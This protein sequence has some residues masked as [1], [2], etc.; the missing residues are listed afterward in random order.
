[1]TKFG[2]DSAWNGGEFCLGHRWSD[3]VNN[4]DNPMSS[5]HVPPIGS[6]YNFNDSYGAIGSLVFRA[7]G[8]RSGLTND[9]WTAQHSSSGVTPA[10]TQTMS[11]PSGT[12]YEN[13]NNTSGGKVLGSGYISGPRGSG[14]GSLLTSMN[15]S[16]IS[17]AR[18]IIPCYVACNVEIDSLNHVAPIGQIPDIFGVN[19]KGFSPEDELT[20]GSDTYVLL[21]IVNSDT[22]LTAQDEEYSGYEGYAIRIRP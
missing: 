5:A 1:M 11:R 10:P 16:L 4:I 22:V 3:N 7:E 12:S 20:I 21:P 14:L 2:G 13:N 15:A 18:A 6:G 8:I 17:N 9:W 19:M